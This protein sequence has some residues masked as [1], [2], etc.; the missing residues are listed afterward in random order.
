MILDSRQSCY[1]SGCGKK[2]RTLERIRTMNKSILAFICFFV[3]LPSLASAHTGLESST[4]ASGQVVVGELT[5]ITLTFSDEIESLSTM[6]LI[7]EEQEIPY[8]KV[9]PNGRQLSGTLSSSLENG[10]YSIRWR[11]VGKDG[12]QI[13]GEI[14]FTVKSEEKADQDLG[15]G[16]SQTTGEETINKEDTE[17]RSVAEKEPA[18]NIFLKL[19][20]PILTL[21][22]LAI[23][24]FL[25]FK[26]KR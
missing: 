24:L 16:E 26:R 11:I 25:L 6:T 9:G 12:H 3:L 20:I 10:A 19:L 14:P 21:A 8:S 23:G 5:K 2:S 1:T 22:A 15:T 17:K 4:P 13:T 7:M 18:T